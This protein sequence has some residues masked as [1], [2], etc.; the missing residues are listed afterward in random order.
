MKIKHI[1]LAMTTVLLSAAC[2]EES[3]NVKDPMV[4]TSQTT[5]KLENADA[6]QTQFS[7]NSNLPWHI[8][9]SPAS[10]GVS[11]RDIKVNP[12]SGQ[13]SQRPIEVTV[14]FGANKDVKREA[15]LSIVT[16]AVG[17][18]VRFI[19]PGAGDPTEVKGTIA[20]PYAPNELVAEMM[21]GA[22]PATDIY[23]RGK[24]S[25]V[26]EIS[27]SYGNATFW[28]TDDGVHP[29]DDKKA[30]QVYRAKDF[31]LANITDENLLK[32]GDVVTILGAVTVYG[33]TT[34][35]TQQNKAQILAVNGVGTPFGA[36][37][38]DLPYNVGMA[39]N[40]CQET[41]TTATEELLVKGV[42]AKIKEISPSYGNATYWITDDGFMPD[43][44][45]SV[46][47]VFRGKWFGGENFTAEDQLK[48][49]DEVVLSG[50]LVNYNGTTPELNQGS[51]LVLLNGT[52]PE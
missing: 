15:V 52:K 24:V 23:V 39:V 1:L 29:D 12:S 22:V 18:S 51:K 26:K 8:V 35:E 21:A 2:T 34:P 19:Q 3:F 30:F 7:F 46:L 10:A 11:V 6:G 41:G 9:V 42:V 27:A 14:S 50:T 33:G 31:G 40:R 28:I 5:I 48:V 13:A 16:D 4:T 36:G 38:E 43:S 44:E 20:T 32:V 47:Q 37:T 25:K 17:A 45:T 49:G